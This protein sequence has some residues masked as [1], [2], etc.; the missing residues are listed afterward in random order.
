MTTKK[1]KAINEKLGMDESRNIEGF[2]FSAI[3]KHFKHDI[4]KLTLN[5]RLVE[6]LAGD[7]LDAIELLNEFEDH[8]GIEIDTPDN[9]FKNIGDIVKIIKKVIN[10]N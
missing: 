3:A 5:T 8:F 2:V 7:S 1:V 10:S 4:K 9:N 6:D